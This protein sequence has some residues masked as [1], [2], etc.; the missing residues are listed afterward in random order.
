MWSLALQAEH[1]VG[2]RAWRHEIMIRREA[3]R[4]LRNGPMWAATPALTPPEK[5]QVVFS[6][7]AVQILHGIY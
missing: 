7:T 2:P 4:R 3:G 5:C 1:T 6:V